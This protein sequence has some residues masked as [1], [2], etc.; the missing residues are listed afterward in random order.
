MLE[1]RCPAAGCGMPLHQEDLAGDASFAE[2][3]QQQHGKQC[4][5]CKH[6]VEKEAGCNKIVCR[7]AGAGWQWVL[8]AGGA[9]VGC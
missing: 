1:A 7:W 3:R 8:L 4:P 5:T 6:W 2:Y 9:E